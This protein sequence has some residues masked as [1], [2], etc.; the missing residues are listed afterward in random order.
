MGC[1]RHAL[2]NRKCHLQENENQ[3]KRQ[4]SIK[5][6]REWRPDSHENSRHALV[7]PICCYSQTPPQSEFAD[8]SS[9]PRVTSSTRA[10]A[11][12]RDDVGPDGEVVRRC[13][14]VCRDWGGHT[15]V[16]DEIEI[17]VIVIRKRVMILQSN[18]S[19]VPAVST[20]LDGCLAIFC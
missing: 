10:E 9:V 6:K 15:A 8:P 3:A 1:Q 18:P 17:S 4:E 11:C 7:F 14:R 16:A 19:S 13:A 20:V 12:T 2:R 5:R